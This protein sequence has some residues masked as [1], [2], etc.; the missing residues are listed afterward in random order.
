MEWIW[1]PA[2][3]AANFRKHGI[4]FEDADL[5]FEDT[6]NIT[7]EDPYF[8]EQRWQTIGAVGPLTPVVIHTWERTE[9]Q[10][11]QGRIISARKANRRERAQYE[12]S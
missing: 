2:K 4:S 3:N 8:Y 7:Q 11:F 10:P 6:G 1:D 12:G 5:V 9:D